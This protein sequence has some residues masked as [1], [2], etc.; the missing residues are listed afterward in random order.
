M[1][2]SFKKDYLLPLP[3]IQILT[4][5]PQEV[6]KYI[7]KTLEQVIFLNQLHNNWLKIEKEVPDKAE[8]RGMDLLDLDLVLL[9][10]YDVRVFFENKRQ[11]AM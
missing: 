9:S 8:I 7:K 2:Q 10:H 11:T 1:S 3:T 6:I 5:K 4:A